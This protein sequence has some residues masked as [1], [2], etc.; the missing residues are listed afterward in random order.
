MNKYIWLVADIVCVGVLI[1]VSVSTNSNETKTPYVSFPSITPISY[2]PI[3]TP[4]K[5]DK[6]ARARNDDGCGDNETSGCVSTTDDNGCVISIK[7]PTQAQLDNEFAES[8][9]KFDAAHCKKMSVRVSN[10]VNKANAYEHT[11]DKDRHTPSCISRMQS[12]FRAIDLLNEEM[13]NPQDNNLW[14]IGPS[15][16]ALSMSLGFAKD[17]LSCAT[18]SSNA[19]SCADMRDTMSGVNCRGWK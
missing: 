8:L 13:R 5:V 16:V 1:I 17:C 15:R 4:V 18:Q 3:P 10:W 7:K 2:Q 11:S 6:C 9:A 19:L 12:D 14:K